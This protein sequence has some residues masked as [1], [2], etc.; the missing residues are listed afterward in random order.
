VV[1]VVIGPAEKVRESS[2]RNVLIFGK[3]TAKQG[4]DKRK[5][6]TSKSP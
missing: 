2:M 1:V 4:F 3:S 6:K 5:N